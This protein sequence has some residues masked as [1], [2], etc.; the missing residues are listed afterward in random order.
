MDDVQLREIFRR[1]AELSESVPEPLREAAFN[2]A[3]DALLNISGNRDRGASKSS[4]RVS[5]TS[6]RKDKE[7]SE[8]SDEQLKQQLHKIDRTAYPEIQK[9]KRVFDRALIALHAAKQDLGIDGL[10]S[11]DVA[12]ILKEKFRIPTKDNAVRMALDRA[13]DKVDRV[14][15]GGKLYFRIMSKGEEHLATLG[16][17][18]AASKKSNS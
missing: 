8:S 14:T 18:D 1:A 5:S 7:T 12:L 17:S 16:K 3:V 6:P 2:R 11:K 4:V 15:L 10:T 13:G 9:T